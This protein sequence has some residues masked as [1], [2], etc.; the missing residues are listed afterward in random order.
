M[1]SAAACAVHDFMDLATIL[2]YTPWVKFRYPPPLG[3]SRVRSRHRAPS[4]GAPLAEC[5]RR[6]GA[7]PAIVRPCLVP[8]GS[9]VYTGQR[10]GRG[11]LRPY[12]RATCAQAF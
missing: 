7:V 6:L 2:G 1:G 10:C 8:D 9:R 5:V 3:V 11:L 12:L 4:G